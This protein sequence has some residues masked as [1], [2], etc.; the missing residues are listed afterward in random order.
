M[1]AASA[2]NFYESFDITW[3]NGRANIFENGQLLTCTLDK[4]SGSGFQSKKE[5]LFGKIDMKLKLVA[6]NSAGT[7]TAYYVQN[8]LVKLIDFESYILEY[9]FI[10]KPIGNKCN[11]FNS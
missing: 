9:L 5:Y 11:I 10:S 7:V 4:V 2:G 3:G 8:L 1:V 6:G